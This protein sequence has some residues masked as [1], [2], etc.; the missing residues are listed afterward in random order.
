VKI[1]VFGEIPKK[2]CPKCG[3]I[4]IMSEKCSRFYNCT[5]CKTSVILIKEPMQQMTLFGDKT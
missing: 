5:K 1:G 3:R 4:M 2:K